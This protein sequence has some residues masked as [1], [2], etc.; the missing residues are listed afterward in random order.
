M[1]RIV[2]GLSLLLAAAGT[3]NAQSVEIA[4]GDWSTVPVIQPRGK[5]RMTADIVDRLHKIA[6]ETKCNISGFTPRRIDLAVP[7]VIQFTPQG[8]I[9]RI[10]LRNMRCPQ[11]ESVLGAVLLQMAQAG[12]YRPT[13][14]N[15]ERWYRSELTFLS[16]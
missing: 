1:K 7:F 10:V 9:G 6:E 14:E 2:L 5:V 16:R 8:G 15:Q 3:A 12:E 13:G 11:L 4:D